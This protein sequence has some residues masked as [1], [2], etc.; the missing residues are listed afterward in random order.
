MMRR[1]FAN[2]FAEKYVKLFVEEYSFMNHMY[3]LLSLF[4][5][6]GQKLKQVYYIQGSRFID[7]R[8]H[9]LLFQPTG[10]GKGSGYSF[11]IKLCKELGLQVGEITEITSAG[12]IGTYDYYDEDAKKWHITEGTLVNTDIVAMEEAE[13]LFI[14]KSDS[15]TKN[16]MTYIQQALNPL[17]DASIALNKKLGGASINVRPHASFCLMSY[18]PECIYEVIVERGF[19]QRFT[20]FNNIVPLDERQLQINYAIEKMKRECEENWMALYRKKKESFDSIVHEFQLREDFYGTNP[21]PIKIKKETFDTAHSVETRCVSYMQNA[22]P[23]AQEMLEHSLFRLLEQI[24][25]Y[26]GLYSILDFKEE[27]EPVDVKKAYSNVIKPYWLNYIQ[28]VESLIEPHSEKRHIYY[29]KLNQICG[30]YSYI[31][32]LYKKKGIT[33]VARTDGFLRYN[34][35][36]SA[37]TKRW[38]CTATT[39]AGYLSKYVMEEGSQKKSWFLK[40]NIDGVDYIK[41]VRTPSSLTRR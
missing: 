13:P 30:V 40:K 34:S 11:F 25:R 29:S 5:V 4:V 1:D 2:E 31:Y 20:V 12:L 10:S 28:F 16:N 22:S 9:L 36:I 41:M 38:E 6:L 35:L 33:K 37:L 26:A 39:A 15:Y 7:L 19:I 14:G 27:V 23:F 32:N 17:W 24:L 8:T 3:G 21:R 18:L